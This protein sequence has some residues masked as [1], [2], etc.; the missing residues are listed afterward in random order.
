MLV[1]KHL[2]AQN[3]EVY[4]AFAENEV[5]R[6]ELDNL[7]GYLLPLWF[8]GISGSADQFQMVLQFNEHANTSWNE[9]K[10]HPELR[11]KLLAALGL[12]KTVQHEFHKRDISR[13]PKQL[14]ALLTTR[15]PDIR[16]EE[17]ALWCSVNNE[18]AVKELCD[19][20]GLQEK[21]RDAIV[22]EYRKVLT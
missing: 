10:D 18:T 11:A 20:Y 8:T 2:D 12:G 3:M 19:Q 22:A 14:T 16:E 1:L 5:E 21:D 15:Y 13:S 4:N 7:L 6:K 17:I 9:L